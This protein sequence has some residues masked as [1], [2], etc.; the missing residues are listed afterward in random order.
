MAVPCDDMFK[1]DTHDVTPYCD[2]VDGTCD[3]VTY[4]KLATRLRYGLVRYAVG[5][6]QSHQRDDT[7]AA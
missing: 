6:W 3:H 1:V 7:I 2:S 4:Q 5:M